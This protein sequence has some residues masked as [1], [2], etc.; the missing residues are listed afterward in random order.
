MVLEGHFLSFPKCGP[1]APGLPSH[2]YSR[3][4]FQVVS[5]FCPLPCAN[6]PVLRKLLRLLLPG[7]AFFLVLSVIVWV[8]ACEC[9]VC[10]AGRGCQA[11][12]EL[13]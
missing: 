2:Q 10:M 13:K 6:Q 12:L 1:G 5:C 9:R 8:C 3:S 7:V 4:L 11:A